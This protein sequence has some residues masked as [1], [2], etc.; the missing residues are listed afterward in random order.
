[1]TADVAIKSGEDNDGSSEDNADYGEKEIKHGRGPQ[2]EIEPLSAAPKAHPVSSWHRRIHTD[3]DRTLALVKKLDSEKGI[4]EN[5]LLTGY[6]GKSNVDKSYVRSTVVIVWGLKTV[7]GLKGV[8]LLDTLLT[9]LW[10]VHGVDYYGMSEM[11]Y[12]KGF[13]H[14]RAENKSDSMAENISAADWEKKLDS[15]WEERLMNGEDPLVLLTAKDKIEAAIV[16]DLEH[17]V[18]KMRD[19]KYIWKYGCGAMGCEKLFHASEYVHKHLKLKHPDLVS[20]VASRVEN[21]MYF[22]NYMK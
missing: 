14:V 3:I 18:R 2:R 11:K 16:E 21:E 4:M 10:R 13:R 20:N 17:Y 12:A 1:M 19:E 15:F 9:Y 6:H 5:I 22:Q 8:E 7:K